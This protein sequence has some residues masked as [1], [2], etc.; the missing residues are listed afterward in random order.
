M[1]GSMKI[2]AKTVL[3]I[4]FFMVICMGCLGMFHGAWL[5]P[6]K[7]LSVL[8]IPGGA[9]FLFF[10]KKDISLHDALFKAF[11]YHVPYIVFVT[12]MV[13]IFWFPLQL[14]KVSLFNVFFAFACLVCFPKGSYVRIHMNRKSAGIVL[15][16]LCM[17]FGM[18]CMLR[19]DLFVSADSMD[20]TYV[21]CNFG[22]GDLYPLVSSYDMGNMW[23]VRGDGVE[24]QAGVR[25]I[26]SIPPQEVEGQ[27][28]MFAGGIR[29]TLKSVTHIYLNDVLVADIP[30]TIQGLG[31][32]R[33]RAGEFS[34]RKT[35]F[36]QLGI[37]DLT[38]NNI[39]TFC[40]E[41]SDIYFEGHLNNGSGKKVLK[42][43]GRFFDWYPV[44]ANGYNFLHTNYHTLPQPPLYFYLCSI[45]ML[46]L[47]VSF[48]ALSHVFFGLVF[49]LLIVI[50]RLIVTDGRDSL[51]FFGASVLALCPYMLQYISSVQF[52]FGDTL[53][54]V[55]FLL[56][57]HFLFLRAYSVAGLC[58]LFV[59]LIRFPGFFLCL[60]VALPYMVI[61]IPKG[62]RMRP[63]IMCIVCFVGMIVFDVIY[64]M[65][66]HGV[67]Q[68]MGCL[69]YENVTPEH[70]SANY[71]FQWS[72]I[73]NFL[74]RA[75]CLT[76]FI[77][78]GVLIKRD[79]RSWLLLVCIM[80]Y[81]LIVASVEHWQW[82]Y[83]FPLICIFI[84]AGLRPLYLRFH[85]RQAVLSDT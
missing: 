70:F 85:R 14:W 48:V 76:G 8:F 29:A 35:T 19:N 31:L 78:V 21:K 23:S 30:H 60:S 6:V 61:F 28:G 18:A 77:G 50:Y 74:L 64:P 62:K 33:A 55:S 83:M 20:H 39:V 67:K 10:E 63:V 58:F 65:Q 80:P 36:F 82:H 7:V 46:F 4:N 42:Q 34:P 69:Y 51:L 45:G 52:M 32:Y 17:V 72:R 37:F 71:V 49:L 47:D 25:G 59:S 81:T 57:I 15:L 68:W 5:M 38:R 1:C 75:L 44:L 12:I 79:A 40:N 27:I 84:I 73:I 3:L 9:L 53:Y 22:R 13:K 54:V 2:H 56:F 43:N 24:M 26:V 16:S 11:V 66:V 41:T